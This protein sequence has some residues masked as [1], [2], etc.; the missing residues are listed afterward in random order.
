MFSYYIAKSV[1]K[2]A[3]A[4]AQEWQIAFEV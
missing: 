2:L 4:D 3:K 1:I